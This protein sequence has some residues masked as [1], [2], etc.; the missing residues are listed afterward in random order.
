MTP[1]S[2]RQPTSAPAGT[3]PALADTIARLRRAMRRAA[4]AADPANPLTVAQLEVLS[5]L[6]RQGPAR[7]ARLA[8]T[9]ALAPNSVTTLVSG[10]HARGLITRSPLPHDARAVVLTCTPAGNEAICRWD[11]INTAIVRAALAA[12]PDAEQHAL[13]A[14]VQ[15]LGALADAIDTYPGP[16]CP[17]GGQCP[18]HTTQGTSPR[19]S[20]SSR[21][22]G[23]SPH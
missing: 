12:L 11:A 20:G 4:R 8:R 18:D 19:R 16:T 13:A 15:A 7:P 3:G 23:I 14:I 21:D 5:C 17:G 22:A 9:L 2:I 1:T 6:A 10:L